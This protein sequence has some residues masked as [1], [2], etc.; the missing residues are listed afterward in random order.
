VNIIARKPRE[1][2]VEY[3]MVVQGPGHYHPF[4]VAS[5]TAHSLASG[6]WFWGHYF[7]TKAEALNFFNGLS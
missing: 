6:E 7:I 2:D 4:V 5:A 1:N 3:I